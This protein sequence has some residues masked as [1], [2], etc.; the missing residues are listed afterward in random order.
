LEHNHGRQ[1]WRPATFN[2][3]RALLSFTYRLAIR[4]GK[5]KQNPARLVPHRRENNARVRFLDDEE[6]AAL[7]KAVEAKCPEHLPEFVLALNT[8]LR[9]SEQYGLL[10]ENV[11]LPLRMLMI[12]RSKNG[13]ARHVPLNQAAVQALEELQ[14][15]HKATALVCGGA[16]EPRRWF[17]LV[18]KDAK[19]IN[20]SWHCLRHTFASRLVMA[21]ADLRTVQELL[22]HK[23]IAMTVRYAHLAPKHTLAAVELLDKPTDGSTDTTTDTGAIQQPAAQPMVLQ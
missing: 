11:S 6:E 13:S 19:V 12:S 20:F 5:V 10:W 8:G 14:K 16:K 17:E 15:Q 23:V 2:R 22:G 1:D 7:R 3:Y 4:D 9:L 18:L 21:G